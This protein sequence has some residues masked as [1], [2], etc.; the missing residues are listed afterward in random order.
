VAETTL[1]ERLRDSELLSS[2]QLAELEPLPEARNP[3][4]KILARV[5]LQRGWLTRFQVSQVAI[6]KG[7]DLFV[8]PYVLLD[9]LG[10][11]G[12]G[13]VLKARHRH[14]KRLVAL[15]LIRKEKLGGADAVS[16][17]YQEVEAAAQ[18]HHPNIVLAFDAGQ[19]GGT[20]FFAM[21][22]V[23]GPDLTR[24]V[25]E[26]GTLPVAQACDFIRQAAVGLQHA[27]E[28]GLVHRDIKPSNLLVTASGG[29]PVVKILDLGL[30]RLGDT[31]AKE[32]NLTKMGQVI[33]T[34][35]YL[36]PEQ[37]MDAH[38]VDI[39]ADIYSL[40]C[41]LYFLL[42]ARAPFQA[43]S[44]TELLMKHQMDEP[45]PIR[46]LRPDV[47]PALESLMRRM[48]AKKAKDRPGTPAEVAAALEP[49]ARGESGGDG[50]PPLTVSIEPVA[51]ALGETWAG[52]SSD[53]AV[54]ARPTARAT[55]SRDTIDE[56]PR[57]R[58]KK[59]KSNKGLLIGGAVGAGVLVLSLVVLGVVMLSSKKPVK[60]VEKMPAP[61]GTL[62]QEVPPPEGVPKEQ[63]AGKPGG[64]GVLLAAVELG[65][66]AGKTARTLQ[67]GGLG[68][69]TEEYNDVPPQGALLTGLEV[70]VGK[71]G[72]QDV[73]YYLRP[74]YQ[75]R[76]GRHLGPTFGA[77]QERTFLLEAK[78]G[79]A[80]GGLA[81]NAG[82]G[83]DGLSAQFMAIKDA[84]LDPSE[85]YSS[86]W[87][88][89]AGGTRQSLGGDG[90]P[91]VGL[92]G[93][94][95][96]T[97]P[98]V[99]NGLGLVM[100]SKGPPVE[101][102]SD[103]KNERL[104]GGGWGGEIYR[105]VA[106]EGGLLIG[107]E[108]GLGK[109]GDIDVT[110]S[111]RA[112]FRSGEKKTSGPQRGTKLDRVTH[113]VAKPGYAVGAAK[114]KNG[115]NADGLSLTFMR[116]KGAV[117]DPADS[118]ESVWVGDVRPG[119]HNLLG[120]GGRPIIGIAIKATATDVTGLGLIFRPAVAPATA[121]LAGEVRKFPVPEGVRPGGLCFHADGK[122]GFT[123]LGPRAVTLDPT[124][125]REEDAYKI[126][127]NRVTA[128]TTSKDGKR[129]LVADHSTNRIRL[130]ELETGKEIQSLEP[131]EAVPSA[132]F[133]ALSADG[134]HA[135]TCPNNEFSLLLWNL[136]TGKLEHTFTD[137]GSFHHSFAFTDDGRYVVACNSGDKSVR[138]WDIKTKRLAHSIGKR[139]LT[140]QAHGLI[141]PVGGSEML[142]NGEDGNF[143]IFDC[144]TGKEVRKFGPPA[145]RYR[146]AL[147]VSADRKTAV[148]IGGYNGSNRGVKIWSGVEM[149][150][151]DIT[152]G[153]K[154]AN[155]ELPTIP[156]LV[157]VSPDG[158][159]ALVAEE[160]TIRY[161]DLAKL[162][163]GD[164]AKPPVTPPDPLGVEV[165]RFD[166]PDNHSVNPVFFMPDGKTGLTFFGP[167]PTKLDP[168][169]GKQI[170]TVRAT[171]QPVP[172]MAQ[173]K[174]RKLVLR[175]DFDRQLR[176]IDVET[177]KVVRSLRSEEYD[178]LAQSV[179]LSP[180]GKH[181][182]TCPNGTLFEK[183]QALRPPPEADGT[184]P[185]LATD[186]V[187]WDLEKGKLEY[188]FG[189]SKINSRLC[190]FTDDG[191][192]AVACNFKL[193]LRVWELK[194]KNLLHTV[195][196][197]GPGL[198]GAAHFVPA[199]GSQI[200][201][202]CWD[203]T[204]LLYDCA[205]GKVVR[206]FTHT[207]PINSTG[208]VMTPDRKT[209]LT[210]GGFVGVFDGKPAV[211][212]MALRVW[213]VARGA[214]VARVDLPTRPV[215][216]AVSPDG[217]FA[218][219][220]DGKV[221]RYLDL[222]KLGRGDGTKP[223]V[224]KLGLPPI[225]PPSVIPPKPDGVSFV[226]HTGAVNCVTLSPDGKQLLSGGEDGA[227]LLWDP[228]TGKLI[229]TI[230][231]ATPVG[232]AIRAVRFTHD[233]ASVL[234]LDD[235]RKVYRWQ[236]KSG[237]S[238]S[239]DAGW[240]LPP[241]EAPGFD[242]CLT[243]EFLGVA[244]GKNLV[245]VRLGSE[246][247]SREQALP[248]A[249]SALCV[250]SIGEGNSFALGDATGAVRLAN[251]TTNKAT[252]PVTISPHKQA[253]L[254]LAYNAKTKHLFSGSADKTIKIT[255]LKRNIKPTPRPFATHEGAVTCLAV[256][257][258]G[259]RLV[260]GSKD[261]TVR[262]WDL[263]TLKEIHKFTDDDE[264]RGVAFAADGRAVYSAGKTLRVWAL[265]KGQKD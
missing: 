186:V 252:A 57:G 152:K 173:S 125:G 251:M 5:V 212:D 166:R 204:L 6:G 262:V 201:V 136:E 215:S 226:G 137:L 145:S 22:Y 58:R 98:P 96:P 218:L 227:V 195:E 87:V 26:K 1:L 8:G 216:V 164:E 155:V 128:L 167:A 75:L 255:P 170:E 188:R 91:V 187:L 239:Y 169:T 144:A 264:V 172:H 183:G 62:P 36:A 246:T 116:V 245:L 24:L 47:P 248:L 99:A 80:I 191:L 233:G 94:L 171:G 214:E 79:Y 238:T 3:D 241:S 192:Y 193:P 232:G 53:G 65:L 67:A 121:A 257:P 123:F 247:L 129:V 224:A 119:S 27:H 17:F 150:V 77:K 61:Q 208:L 259:K 213:D 23:E 106:P 117:L 149:Q 88:G 48:M 43:E 102:P 157:A 32:R 46:S 163:S 196:G 161:F 4:P 256:S 30:A 19:A 103:D 126:G 73:I 21:E 37:A 92:F 101:A 198:K 71:W 153:T 197:P 154:V 223:A 29:A 100:L 118:Y 44:L 249:A 51:P 217:K 72:N 50:P 230:R 234:A 221:T 206:Q 64:D 203:N 68:G 210:I 151:W 49:L 85:S 258:N 55:R 20:H 108:V 31:F 7:K 15:K 60:T 240:R 42:A 74:V 89:G 82:A 10:E 222:A 253:V 115:A 56:Q 140:V 18:L 205:T 104:V 156:K 162:A 178:T 165:R 190:A 235:V 143:T 109:F 45:A 254:V 263:T 41:S 12:M 95:S 265:S 209:A 107:L 114:V 131:A 97:Q 176:L 147:V 124:T 185:S 200:L 236:T 146:N 59:E 194:T 9:K 250:A 189:G 83:L 76:G 84:A 113:L 260:S 35:D 220:S 135:L 40:G 207:S 63:P 139:D 199:G 182:L 229:R 112:V 2:E 219:V 16:R 180:D 138:V 148:T 141:A 11:G 127:T 93:K 228:A 202:V 237:R 225:D 54:V 69:G 130:L 179:A 122:R 142:V 174:D 33:G 66:R 39:R 244:V 120:G 181:A 70:G 81:I 168:S 38:N 13:Q 177:G 133:G 160:R 134:K 52:L 243:D 175:G 28:R 231:A 184:I 110:Q 78:P 111:L 211:K 159:S 132:I 242:L 25:R 90:T 14:M 105:D 34:P 158:K 86:D 261:R